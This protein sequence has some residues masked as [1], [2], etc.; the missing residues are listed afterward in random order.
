[1]L[2]DLIP[3][4]DD[5]IEIKGLTVDSRKVEPGFLFAAFKGSQV[6]GRKFI[7]Q[8]IKAGAA[9][10]LAPDD[11]EIT[12]VGD[13]LVVYDPNPRL[14]FADIASS[15]YNKQ[16]KC[17]AA[18]TGTNGKSSCV[19]FIREMW[20]MLGQ[21]AA[22]IGTLGVTAPGLDIYGGLTTPDAAGL[23]ERLAEI[24]DLGVTHL[25]MEAS[26]HGLDQYRMDGV[27]VKIAAF[28]NLSRDHLDYHADMDEYLT[29]KK[30]L[31]SEVLRLGGISVLNADA[32]E[33]EELAKSTSSFGHNIIAYGKAG[34]SIKLLDAQATHSGQQIKLLI[35]EKEY[36]V[37]LPLA[38][39]FQVENALC[40]LG[41]VMA[42][43]VPADDAVPLLEKLS[44][45]PGRM[46]LI[47]KGVYVDFAHTTDA[48]KTVLQAL[49]P[50]TEGDLLV[51]FGCGGDRDRGKRAEMGKVATDLAD[52]IYVTDDNPRT[53][54]PAFVRSE[55]MAACSDAEEI[56]DRK[57][58]I[59][60]AIASM[61]KGDVLVVAGKGH[62]TGQIVGTE[63]LPFDDRAVVKE[64][65]NG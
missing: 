26:S 57:L 60:T 30:R 58:A 40:S 44:G 59:Q 62:E 38:G 28:T 45:V 29:V 32:P 65:L 39:Y 13:A 63:V 18:V 2:N 64:V 25:A 19:T 31:F 36:D 41:V 49:R 4:L 48:L 33:Y 27:S 14:R 52:R 5:K 21:Q 42:S 34:Q 54:D 50:H 11:E 3:S 8:A 1:M 20:S 23:H 9:V 10:I 61:K 37:T 47:G 15:F 24:S 55:I 6:D 16:P 43:G 7:P 35:E 46:E 17:V 53:E 56:G 51:V 22:S 12:D